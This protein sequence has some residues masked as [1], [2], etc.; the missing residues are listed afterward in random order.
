M[1]YAGQPGAFKSALSKCKLHL[2]WPVV[3]IQWTKHCSTARNIRVELKPRATW[4]QP[5]QVQS[6]A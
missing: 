6:F 5:V 1:L 2:L 3:Q 4:V